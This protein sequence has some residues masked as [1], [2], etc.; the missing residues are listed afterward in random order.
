MSESERVQRWRQRQREAGKEPLTIW[1]TSAEKLRL[2][3][4]ALSMRCSPSELVQRLLAQWHGES[5]P[6]T[7]TVTDTEQLR[8]VTDAVADTMRQELPLLVRL[9]VEELQ[10]Q[11]ALPVTDTVTDTILQGV[12]DTVT[13]M[14]TSPLSHAGNID[15]TATVTDTQSI[16]TFTVTDTEEAIEAADVTATVTDTSPV[17]GADYRKETALERVTDT[18]TDTTTAPPPKRKAP[19]RQR[20]VT[21]T[22]AV[23]AP[24]LEPFD[25]TRYRLGKLCPKGHAFGGTGQSLL[26]THNQRCRECENESRREKRQARRQAPGARAEARWGAP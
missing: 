12:T 21:D 10:L 24:A 22:V 18:V 1:L 3:D 4:Q 25:T 11:S 7:D 16:V 9:A 14:R 15:V 8:A 13:A 6:V 2:E 17:P 5:S 23:T 26:R 19:A 20:A